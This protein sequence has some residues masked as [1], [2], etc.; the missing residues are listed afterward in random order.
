MPH[1]VVLEGL[2]PSDYSDNEIA[3][4]EHTPGDCWGADICVLW[5][6]ADQVNRLR[7]DPDV[8]AKELDVLDGRLG[9]II[10]AAKEYG[11]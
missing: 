4:K 3:D 9:A 8:D 7:G 1:T 5:A 2:E 6:V 11:Y 10:Q